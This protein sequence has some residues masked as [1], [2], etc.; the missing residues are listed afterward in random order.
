M[1]LIHTY[2][3]IYVLRVKMITIVNNYC[4]IT[5]RKCCNNC[6]H[7]WD[8]AMSNVVAVA[9]VL[10]KF[11]PGSQCLQCKWP[12]V[13]RIDLQTQRT[14][15]QWGESFQFYLEIDPFL[16]REHAESMNEHSI[17]GP[18]GSSCFSFSSAAHSRMLSG[19]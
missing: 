5:A 9:G 8:D 11:C 18:S 3:Y 15:I 4:R 1:K 17:V 16:K 6:I 12:Q 2:I 7:N 14:V 19:P 10:R 13:Q